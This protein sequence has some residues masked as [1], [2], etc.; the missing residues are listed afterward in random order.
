MNT[1]IWCCK[2]QPNVSF[3]ND[4]HTIPK[5][6]GGKNLCESVCDTCNSYF[7]NMHDKLPAIETVIKETFNI[8]RLILLDSSNDIGKNKSLARFKSVFFNVDMQ[9]R[10]VR[11][12]PKFSLRKN[13]QVDLGR[14]L[15][16]GIFKIYLEERE[17]QIGDALDDKFNF[18]RE[19]SRYNLGNYPVLYFNV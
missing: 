10:K 19:F 13:F 2:S 8:S 17:R 14:L 15:R 5:S 11:I 7:G 4:A 1:R 16:R 3:K 6:L 12:K 9:K 18:I